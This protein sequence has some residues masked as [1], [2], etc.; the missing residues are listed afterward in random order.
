M[1][2]NVQSMSHP[3]SNTLLYLVVS[4]VGLLDGALW[5]LL[6]AD[7]LPLSPAALVGLHIALCVVLFFFVRQQFKDQ[8]LNANLAGL[9]TAIQLFIFSLFGMISMILIF[10]MYVKDAF[11]T[12]TL[13]H[14]DHEEGEVQ[15][16][17]H[18]A[19]PQIDID[20]LRFVS[21]LIDGM[22]EED[23][24]KRIST[25]QAMDEVASNAVHKLLTKSAP[26][27][28]SEAEA[29][30]ALQQVSQFMLDGKTDPHKEVQ[31]FA[32]DAVKKIGDTYTAEI[33]KLTDAVNAEDPNYETYKKLADTYAQFAST[34][35]DHPI[36]I[37]FYYQ[38][39]AK[40]YAY[41]VENY[42]ERRKEVL[43]NMIPALYANRE[44]EQCLEYCEEVQ[45]DPELSRLALLYKAA[46]LFGMR[47]IAALK[48]FV[49]SVKDTDIPQIERFAKFSGI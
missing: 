15:E 35:T 26:D 42:P 7:R 4:L 47:K 1:E 8:G 2:Q 41:I 36:L 19:E 39:A 33:K 48:Q 23:I 14:I 32:N 40:Y 20:E 11:Q 30:D 25:V 16:I 37:K 28:A 3:K 34:N 5:W 24:N 21:P 43:K 22:T 31:Y 18:P 29:F 44:Y 27:E 49:A 45:Q 13:Y 17:I 6:L 9:F 12:G 10:R 46:S 38:E